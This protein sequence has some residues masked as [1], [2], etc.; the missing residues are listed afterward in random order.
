M[1]WYT[2]RG[3][4]S[5]ISFLPVPS[6]GQLLQERIC[7]SWSKFLPLR[8]DL[9][10]KGLCIQRRKQE[11]TKLFPF[12]KIAEKHGGIPINQFHD[13]LKISKK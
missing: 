5:V 11:V 3:N 2:F 13:R 10:K 1:N 4:N 6:R 7:Y 8:V 12:V 9:F